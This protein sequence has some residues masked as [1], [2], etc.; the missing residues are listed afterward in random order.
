M[1]ALGVPHPRNR[2]LPTRSLLHRGHPAHAG[3]ILTHQTLPLRPNRFPPRHLRPD[4]LQHSLESSP[5]LLVVL[6][7]SPHHPPPRP[8]PPHPLHLFRN[9]PSF[10]QR[11]GPHQPSPPSKSPHPPLNN[12]PPSLPLPRLVLLRDLD[13]LFLVFHLLPP[14]HLTPRRH[15]PS[16]PRRDLRLPRSPHNRTYPPLKTPCLIH[17]VIRATG[18]LHREYIT[19][20]CACGANVLDADFLEYCDYAVGDGYEFPGGDGHS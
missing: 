10:S 3:P 5:H 17:H 8:P 12:L 6:P 2:M 7:L 11:T 1:V 13:L 9:P 18:F 16:A 15:P 19:G 20:V 14:A 4:P